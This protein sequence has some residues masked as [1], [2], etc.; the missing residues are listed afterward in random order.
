MGFKRQRLTPRVIRDLKKRS[1]VGIVFYM[2][3]VSVV[4]LAD[5]YYLRHP[6]FSMQFVLLVFGICLFRFFHRVVEPWIPVRL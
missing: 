2:I 1:T 5:G 3:A 4:L 6:F